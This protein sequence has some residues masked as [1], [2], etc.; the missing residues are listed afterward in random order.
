VFPAVV[1]DLFFSC[2]AGRCDRTEHERGIG[3][4]GGERNLLVAIAA[5]GHFSTFNV[6]VR[7]PAPGLLI[8]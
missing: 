5:N 7:V 1:E 8:E 3:S 6:E 4:G 2:S